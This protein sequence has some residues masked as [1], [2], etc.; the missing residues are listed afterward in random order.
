MAAQP[1]P[2]TIRTALRSKRSA[3]EENPTNAAERSRT[4]TGV[5]PLEPESSASASS[6]TA[7]RN[8]RGRIPRERPVTSRASADTRAIPS[9]Q[10][11]ERRYG[12]YEVIP[13]GGSG[14]PA[15]LARLGSPHQL[16][17]T[18]AAASESEAP[19]FS[20]SPGTSSPPAPETLPDFP[21]ASR[22]AS[23]SRRIA[24]KS[25]GLSLRNCLTFSRP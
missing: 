22:P 15:A 19:L 5:T 18:R 2:N 23:T 13:N 1:A 25:S 17:R 10:G 14:N 20:Y 24:S 7:A 12:T 11:A 3:H 21:E 9:P 8:G 16:D 4:S 6:A